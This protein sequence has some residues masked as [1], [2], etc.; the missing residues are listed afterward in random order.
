[1]TSVAPAEVG[2]SEAGGER[3]HPA[4]AV[5]GGFYLFTGGVH[6]GIVAAGTGFYRH[7]ADQALVPFVHDRWVDVFMPHASFWGLC[8]ML[9]ET[10]LGILLFLGGRWAKVGWVG[11]IAFNVLLVLFGWGFLLWSVPAV[12]V[13]TFLAVRDW[14]RLSASART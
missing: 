1:M 9:G 13:L 7:F 6:L 2:S 3:R 14:P 11:V 12:G 8:L 5:V 4:R 10:M